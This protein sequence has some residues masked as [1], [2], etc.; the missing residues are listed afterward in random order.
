MKGTLCAAKNPGTRMTQN[1]IR[2]MPMM[3]H[4]LSTIVTSLVLNNNRNIIHGPAEG[5]RGGR[6]NIFQLI[7]HFY[8]LLPLMG[9]GL[10]NYIPK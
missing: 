6:S 3:I 1:D 9:M 5:K 2:G 8:L 7:R 10:V 4:G